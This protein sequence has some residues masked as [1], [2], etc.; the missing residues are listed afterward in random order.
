MKKILCMLLSAAMLVSLAACGSTGKTEEPG[1]SEPTQAPENTTPPES[2]GPAEETELAELPSPMLIGS[3]AATGTVFQLATAFGEL[4]GDHAGSQVT[5]QTTSGANENIRLTSVGDVDIGWITVTNYT[6]EA[7]VGQGGFEGN[8]VTNIK[9]LFGALPNAILIYAR[10]DSGIDSIRDM[11]GKKIATGPDGQYCS[12]LFHYLLDAYGIEVEEIKLPWADCYEGVQD[13]DID[14]MFLQGSWPN[15]GIMNLA[16]N[17]ELN[18]IELTD[19][20]RAVLTENDPLLFDCTIPAG[21][22]VGL[23]DYPTLASP[24]AF[25]VRDDMDEDVAYTITKLIL[26]HIH[27]YDSVSAT[28]AMFD[29]S[30]A[31]NGLPLEDIHPGALRYFKEIGL[32][33]EN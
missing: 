19:E 33:K 18:Y 16:T 30:N 26:E 24:T 29:S 21:T 4:L 23:D 28:V 27:E 5:A 3:T 22:Y 12:I 17:L 8:P 20:D 13:G 1:S 31:A 25:I 9:L 6:L 32:I 15:S 11:A 14:G 10:P 2:S 7:K